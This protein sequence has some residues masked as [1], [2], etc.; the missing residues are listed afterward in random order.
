[1]INFNRISDRIFVGSCPATNVD[2]ARLAQ[3]GISAVVNLQ[4]DQDFVVLGIDWPSLEHVYFDKGIEVYRFPMI[5]FD[6]ADIESRLKA[7]ATVVNNALDAGHRI[8]LHCTAGQERSPTTAAAWLTLFGGQSPGDAL[9]QVMQARK[10]RPY[11][12]MV[13][14]LVESSS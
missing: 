14:R 9:R 2:V 3:A 6:E 10:S 11:A 7:A 5:D 8:Y 13:M 12:G 4:S 1:M